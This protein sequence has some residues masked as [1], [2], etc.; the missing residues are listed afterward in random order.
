MAKWH[1]ASERLPKHDGP[2]IVVTLDFEFYLA[3][4]WVHSETG[5]L[6]FQIPTA[7]GR[8]KIVPDVVAWRKIDLG[9][10]ERIAFPSN[11]KKKKKKKKP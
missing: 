6:A 5:G 3:N 1:R 8:Y 10:P 9:L 11:V 2:V 4:Y 7:R